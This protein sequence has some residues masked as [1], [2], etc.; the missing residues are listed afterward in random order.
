[1]TERSGP[2]WPV[3]SVEG[4]GAWRGVSPTLWVR[5]GSG[6]AAVAYLGHLLVCLVTW[7]A[8]IGDPIGEAITFVACTIAFLIAPR[9]PAAGAA[10]SCASV[11]AE[12]YVAAAIVETQWVASLP[13]LPV[14]VL[15]TGLFFGARAALASSIAGILVYPLAMLAAGKIGPAVGGIPPHELSR[16]MVISGALA[17][18]GLMTWFALRALARLH[19]EAA[20]RRELEVTLQHAQRLQMVGELAGGVAHDF[21]N[22]LGVFQNAA[23]LLAASDH[24]PSRELAAELLQSVRS[25]QGITQRLLTLARKAEAR[26]EVIDVAR[27]VE[28]IRPLVTRLVG[29]RCTLSMAAAGP[30]TAVAD[31]VEVEQVVL[32]L[33][34][35]ARDAMRGGGAVPV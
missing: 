7:P 26:R 3:T 35:N 6:V 23:A 24:G 20:E 30:A 19:A 33:A 5:V 29:P 22:V 4:L 12:V 2:A 32:N 11:A 1:M 21:R 25:G 27:A 31:P 34:A 9:W 14:V 28:E 16:M 15:A 10:I 8:P 18:A 13:V 17:G